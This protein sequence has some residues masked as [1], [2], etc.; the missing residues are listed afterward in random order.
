MSDMNRMIFNCLAAAACAGLLCGC[1][2]H[3]ETVYQDAPRVPIRFEN[4]TAA[5]LFY[6]TL[7]NLPGDRAGT[8]SRTKIEL[9]IIFEHETTVAR[10]PNR[11][12]KVAVARCDTDKDGLITEAEARIFSAQK[13]KD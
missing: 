9:P 13:G 6:E 12:F 8:E 11:A 5:R 3:H 7:S 4:D 1:I 10:G 2:S